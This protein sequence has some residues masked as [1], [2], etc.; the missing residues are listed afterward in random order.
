MPTILIPSTFGI[1]VLSESNIY[2]KAAM[3]VA[4]LITSGRFV[5]LRTPRQDVKSYLYYYN[6]RIFSYLI[7]DLY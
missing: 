6:V 1:F 3:C 2:V 4:A 7:R 5:L